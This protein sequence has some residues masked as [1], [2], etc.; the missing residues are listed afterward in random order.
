MQLNSYDLPHARQ[1]SGTRP[2]SCES[3]TPTIEAGVI[4]GEESRAEKQ[5]DIP[6]EPKGQHATP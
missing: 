6:P 3:G 1:D 2:L 4:A 5:L